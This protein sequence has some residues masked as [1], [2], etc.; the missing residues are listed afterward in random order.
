MDKGMRVPEEATVAHASAWRR[1]D[2]WSREEELKY[3]ISIRTF[4]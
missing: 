4:I 3:I 1:K 2:S